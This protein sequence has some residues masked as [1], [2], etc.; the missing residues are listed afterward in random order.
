MSSIDD[1]IAAMA[2]EARQAAR[3]VARAGT[4]AKNAAL[5]EMTAAISREAEGICA[6]NA[7]DLQAARVAGLSAAMIDRL[8]IGPGTIAAMAAGLREV[9]DLPDPVG[10][11]GP[12]RVRPNGLEIARMRIPLGVIGIIYE[13][14]PNVTVDAAALCLK[15]GNAVLLRGGS[16]ALHSNRAL[17]AVI[18]RALAAAGLPPA[19]VQVVPTAA[20]AAVS[21]LTS[22]LLPQATLLTPNA[23]EAS[24]LTGITTETTDDLRRAGHA[25]LA[26]GVRAVLM[27]GGHIDGERVIDILMTP[28]GETIFEGERIVTRHTHGTGCTL[29]SAC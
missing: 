18:G 3:A 16:E 11:C 1:T 29:A 7:K 15:A 27:K 25:L 13:S 4:D 28:A 8:T 21:A 23:P 22:L 14:R 12:T 6:A 24:A 26:M 10:S 19:A 2:R 17:A 20:R 9:A 5:L